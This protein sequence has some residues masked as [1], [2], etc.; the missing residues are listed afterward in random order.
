MQAISARFLEDLRDALR[1]HEVRYLFI[2][3]G[4]AIIQGFV[5]TTQDADLFVDKSPE[6]AERLISALRQAGAA[7]SDEEADALRKGKDF[8]QLGGEI[9]IDV[10]HAPDGIESQGVQRQGDAGPEHGEGLRITRTDGVD[11]VRPR[12]AVDLGAR[13]SLLDPLLFIVEPVRQ[14]GV[15]ASVD[16]QIGSQT[17]GSTSTA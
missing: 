16:H 13:H 1:E 14:E 5:D 6:N 3:K 12:A 17:F 11:A 4:A 15:H 10:V 8:V 7:I 9:S 2:G